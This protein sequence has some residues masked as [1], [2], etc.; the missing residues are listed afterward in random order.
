MNIEQTKMG[1][2]PNIIN[3]PASEN[4]SPAQALDS[5]KKISLE[6]VLI[7]GYDKE[8][9]LVVRSSRMTRKDAL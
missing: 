7:I 2:N 1:I 8:G 4:F 5:A 9:E 3:L 6:D